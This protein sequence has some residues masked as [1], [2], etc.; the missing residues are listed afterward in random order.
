MVFGALKWLLSHWILTFFLS[1]FSLLFC[2]VPSF[3]LLSFSSILFFSPV[4]FLLIHSC[5]LGRL[6]PP[7]NSAGI[8]SWHSW[9]NTWFDF[10]TQL[11]SSCKSVRRWSLFLSFSFS[12][13]LLLSLSTFSRILCPWSLRTNMRTSYKSNRAENWS[14]TDEGVYRAA[15]DAT[16]EVPKSHNCDG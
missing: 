11:K 2:S 13:F 9:N 4:F 15:K 14:R 5:V 8:T 7:V 10:T 6:A 3:L 12:F 1:F 16:L